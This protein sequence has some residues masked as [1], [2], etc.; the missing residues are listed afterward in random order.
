M[1]LFTQFLSR[2][3][4]IHTSCVFIQRCI[5]S[6]GGKQFA[7]LSGGQ[8]NLAMVDEDECAKN[9]VKILETLINRNPR[10]LERM[11]IARKDGGWHCSEP[12]KRYWHILHYS[13]TNRHVNAHVEHYNGNMVAS[14]ST[15]EWA[16]RK[17]LYSTSDVI[18]ASTVGRV[19][20]RRCLQFGI[21]YVHIDMPKEWKTYEKVQVFLEGL[22]SEGLILCEPKTILDFRPCVKV[23]YFPENY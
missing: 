21:S 12:K 11:A 23:D 9:D 7:S 8:Q 19:L 14:A 18:A 13:T 3:P 1:A 22:K 2:V 4:P 6:S 10:N 16:I 20:G 17:H 15:M 5:A